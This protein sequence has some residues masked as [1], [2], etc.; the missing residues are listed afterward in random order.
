[1][2]S[3]A[4]SSCFSQEQD[5]SSALHS[6]GGFV[7]VLLPAKTGTKDCAVKD[8]NRTILFMGISV[9]HP[10]RTSAARTANII[11]S[12]TFA[13]KTLRDDHF[14]IWNASVVFDATMNTATSGA[15]KA[16]L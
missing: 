6:D 11:P 8:N 4:T 7:A 16:R 14:A 5:A 13:G 1:M 15:M 3:S 2:Q 10:N 9:P 12:P